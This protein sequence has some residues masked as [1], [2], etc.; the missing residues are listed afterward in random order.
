MPDPACGSGDRAL[1]PIDRR[2]P[3]PSRAARLRPVRTHHLEKPTE[4]K[5]GYE[6]YSWETFNKWLERIR[7]S[8]AFEY[9]S[10]QLDE[11]VTLHYK[12]RFGEGE[13]GSD[14]KERFDQYVVKI[15]DQL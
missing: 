9:N 1:S 13:L 2:S 14:E 6:R 10:E 11:L 7:T 5:L 8:N 15:L 12:E 4:K 3:R